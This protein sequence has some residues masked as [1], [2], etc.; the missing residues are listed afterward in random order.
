MSL[1]SFF[2]QNS[3]PMVVA[4]SAEHEPTPVRPWVRAVQAAV[5]GA[6]MIGT[7]PSPAAAADAMEAPS[8]SVVAYVSEADGPLLTDYQKWLRDRIAE[9]PSGAVA[10][11][12]KIQYY[13]IHGETILRDTASSAAGVASTGE[14]ASQADVTA[15]TKTSP[16]AEASIDL[17]EKNGGTCVINPAFQNGSKAMV[18][19]LLTGGALDMNEVDLTAMSSDALKEFLLRHE[20]SHCQNLGV[21]KLGAMLAGVY[22]KQLAATVESGNP[23]WGVEDFARHN[24]ETLKNG[25]D[26]ERSAVMKEMYGNLESIDPSGSTRTLFENPDFARVLGTQM[27][28]ALD[29]FK[30]LPDEALSGSS[31]ARASA[32][33]FE[34]A[35]IWG[36]HV[37]E[38]AAGSAAVMHLAQIGMRD[39]AALFSGL[40]SLGITS[41][42]SSKQPIIYHTGPSQD[43]ALEMIDGIMKDGGNLSYHAINDR[44]FSIAMEKAMDIDE[45]VNLDKEIKNGAAGDYLKLKASEALEAFKSPVAADLPNSMWS[46]LLDDTTKTS[47]AVKG[48][49]FVDVVTMV[50]E[51]ERDL[52]DDDIE[53][54]MQAAGRLMAGLSVLNEENDEAA[55]TSFGQ[56]IASMKLMMEPLGMKEPRPAP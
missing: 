39:D 17:T 21:M 3:G 4:S 36:I 22:V 43:M 2:R 25:S 38:N 14:P 46:E 56:K 47:E 18:L 52:W 28:I 26:A 5:L 30:A 1:T 19:S 40:R 13:D 49:P 11:G 7:L 34:K 9:T 41:S 55:R 44:A 31:V 51:A 16:T 45:L 35:T 53:N 24:V 42:A 50:N 15:R 10:F 29:E 23:R 37:S 8:P 6:V 32:S 27:G 54:D 12:D 48:Q 33:A 20:Q